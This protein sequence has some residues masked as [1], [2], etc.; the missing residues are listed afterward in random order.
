MKVVDSPPL[1]A[2]RL[3]ERTFSTTGTCRSPPRIAVASAWWNSS[4]RWFRPTWRYAPGSWSMPW[5]WTRFRVGRRFTGLR[6]SWPA[7]TSS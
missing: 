6:S 1:V 7:R 3:P 2:R 4:T 5:F